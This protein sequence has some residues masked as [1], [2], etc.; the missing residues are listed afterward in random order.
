MYKVAREL[1]DQ[2]WGNAAATADALGV[3]LLTW[4][5]AAYRYGLFDF[6]KLEEFLSLNERDLTDFRQDR[7]QN[8]PEI[9][10]QLVTRLFDELLQALITG[11][12]TRSPVAV[13]KALHL[14]AP[15]MFPLW[16]NKIATQY[17]CR[18]YGAPGSSKKY[19][20]FIAIN[21]DQ[22]TQLGQERPISDIEDELSAMARFPKPILKFV[23]EYNYARFTYGWT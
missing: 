5:Q 4:N 14:I 12:G 23:D 8:L 9:N 16:D 1:L 7:L 21:K 2:H 11:A 20:Q 19:V 13:G 22:L 17:G 6:A 15:R 3:L 10:A 18:I